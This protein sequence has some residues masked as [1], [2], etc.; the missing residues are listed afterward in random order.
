MTSRQVVYGVAA[1]N[2]SDVRCDVVVSLMCRLIFQNT[3]QLY[4]YAF[5][6]FI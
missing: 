3:I 5:E 2:Y 4:E 6:I 1:T